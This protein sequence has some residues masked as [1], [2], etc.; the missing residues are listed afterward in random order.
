MLVAKERLKLRIDIQQ[1]VNSALKYPGVQLLNLDSEIA[2]TS[3]RLPGHFNGDPADRLI[4][5]TCMKHNAPLLT[6]DKQIHDWGN[7]ATSGNTFIR[8]KFLL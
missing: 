4:V 6:K 5:A 3:T 2:V 1:W 8:V 7:I